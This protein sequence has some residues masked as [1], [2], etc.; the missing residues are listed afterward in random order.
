M[1]TV[2]VKILTASRIEERGEFTIQVPSSCD[3]ALER[4][5]DEL[6]FSLLER[7]KFDMK[8]LINGKEVPASEWNSI[9]LTDGD[10]I[11]VIPGV[12]GG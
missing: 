12:G 8:L 10:R 5:E 7:L 4:I 11:V 1:V 2:Q 3:R 9:E 6:D